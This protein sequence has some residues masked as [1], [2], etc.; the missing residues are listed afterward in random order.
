MILFFGCSND[1][2]P[3]VEGTWE[4]KEVHL[5]WPGRTD[6]INDNVLGS[7]SFGNEGNFIFNSPKG[8]ILGDYS[9]KKR[10]IYLYYGKE[11]TKWTI[12]NLNDKQL[13]LSHSDYEISDDPHIDDEWFPASPSTITNEVYRE[14]YHFVKVA[15]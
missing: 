15:P 13:I 12:L 14:E 2:I 11:T 9:I 4:L 6:Y 1:P 3:S 5:I 7:Y 10:T 8:A